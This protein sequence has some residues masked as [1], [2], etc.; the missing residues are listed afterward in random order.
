MADPQVRIDGTVAVVTGARQGMGSVFAEALARAGAR[1]ACVDL[2]ADEELLAVARRSNGCAFGADCSDP[3]QMRDLA[4]LVE[5]ELG[6]AGILVANHAYMSMAPVG[7]HDVEDW[8]N[9]VDTNLGGT[10][11][12]IQSFLPQLRASVDSAS[13]AKVVVMT[14]EWGVI[15]WPEATAYAAS[16]AGL[17]SLVKTLARELSPEGIVV[18]GIAPGVTDTPQLQVDAV[19]AGV[20]IDEIKS[21]YALNIPLG[22]IARPEDIANVLLYLVN[23][24]VRSLTG[25]IVQVN[26]GSTRTRA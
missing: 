18:N 5:S 7:K 14:S 26:G 17:V 22:R 9:I 2:V 3:K 21:T 20:S 24:R 16:K 15:G 25:Q 4:R 13:D 12:F 11:F 8:W 10:F 23:P 19:S 6:S 1:V